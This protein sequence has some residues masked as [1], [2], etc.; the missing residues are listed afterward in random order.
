MSI[1]QLRTE[2]R[3]L[4]NLLIRLHEPKYKV[5]IMGPV[6]GRLT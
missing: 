6:F 1:S 4:K 5:L 2:V 3:E